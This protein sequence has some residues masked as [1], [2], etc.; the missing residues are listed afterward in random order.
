[1]NL[2][3]S[4]KIFL[5]QFKSPLVYILV[6]AG[7]VTFFLREFTD[8][9]VIFAAVLLN[10]SLGFY[11]ERKA[12]K[13]LA[14]L[15]SLLAPKA[16]V[17]RNSNQREIDTAEVVPGDLI[18]HEGGDKIPAAPTAPLIFLSCRPICSSVISP[19]EIW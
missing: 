15:R 19:V 9:F 10:T 3:F 14:A 2:F 8:S 6:L 4:L 18:V 1:M 12:Q 17:I 11:Q 5:F 13:S 16:K 7:V